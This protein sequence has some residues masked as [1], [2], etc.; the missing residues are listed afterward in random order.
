MRTLL[1][2]EVACLTADDAL[3]FVAARRTRSP[4]S[5]V[6]QGLSQIGCINWARHHTPVVRH[7]EKEFSWTLA[8]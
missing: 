8:S 7:S 1:D 4:S 3:T 6:Q 5:A 2:E